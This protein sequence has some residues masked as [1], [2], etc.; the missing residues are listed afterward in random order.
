MLAG[1]SAGF[2]NV[3]KIKGSHNAMK[4]GMVAGEQIFEKFMHEEDPEYLDKKEITEYED[5]IKK[6]WVW[7]D[8]Y[9][10]RNIKGGFKKYGLWGGVAHAGI[11]QLLTKGREKWEF[12]NKTQD[13]QTTGLKKDYKPINYPKKDGKLTFD[14]LT[15]VSRTGTNHDHDQPA[16]LKIK[17]G[18]D[19]IPE[20]LS[21]KDY[22]GPEQRFCPAKVYEYIEDE[23]GVEKL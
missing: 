21:L 23:N 1:C 11:V 20:D 8:M 4:S 15:S 10:T 3:A 17:E 13:S 5:A 14:I 7:D 12:T 2:L 19:N 18:L 6:S 16:H 22:A 9:E